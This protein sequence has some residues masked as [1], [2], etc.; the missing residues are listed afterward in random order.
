MMQCNAAEANCYSTPHSSANGCLG[1]MP[2]AEHKAFKKN[3]NEVEK[4]TEQSW[5]LRM[6]WIHRLVVL[7]YPDMSGDLVNSTP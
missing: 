4:T 3:H 5:V 1:Q 2:S 7:I 6:P